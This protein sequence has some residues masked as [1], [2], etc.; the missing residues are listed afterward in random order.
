MFAIDEEK[1]LVLSDGTANGAA[2]IVQV[3]LLPRGGEVAVGI[4][5]GVAQKFVEGPVK[6]VGPG[7]CG[8]QHGG[9]GPGTVFGRIGVGQD[10]EFL[11]AIDGGENGDTARSEFVI[12]DAIQQPVCGVGA[13]AT[14]R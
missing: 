9:S 3:E 14:D 6:V 4:E 2:K 11:N 13:G 10:L 12:V 8:D 1:G 5:R 7:F